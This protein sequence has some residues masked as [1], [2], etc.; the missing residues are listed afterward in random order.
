MRDPP[1][2]LAIAGF[3]VM[4]IRAI[5]KP[6]LVTALFGILELRAAGRNDVCAVYGGCG[7]HDG[8]DRCFAINGIG[9]RVLNAVAA[10]RPAESTSHL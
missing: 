9:R 3:F 7:V 5:A 8:L 4:G 2:D 10:G 1:V 6:S